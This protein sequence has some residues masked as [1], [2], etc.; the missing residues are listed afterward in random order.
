[1]ATAP[2]PSP[3]APAASTRSWPDGPLSTWSPSTGR[4]PGCRAARSR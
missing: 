4:S 3:T 1:L 2:T